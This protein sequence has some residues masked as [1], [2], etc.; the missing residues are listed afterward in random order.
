M[1]IYVIR[2]GRTNNNDLGLFNG[3]TDED[4]ND[5]GIEQAKKVRDT[6]RKI[7]I[8]LIICSPMKRT[9]HTADII[10]INNIPII[11]DDRLIE[12]D[13]GDI[14]LMPYEIIDR[15]E[16]WNR[17]STKYKNVE[18]VNNLLRRVYSCINDI[19]KNYNNKNILIVTHNG[20]ARAIYAYFN[21]MPKDG[22]IWKIGTQK[23]CEIR[24]Y[25][26]EYDI[27]KD[28]VKNVKER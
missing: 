26:I 12:R 10:N 15:E 18:T 3:R 22:K 24:K 11:Y 25:N 21:G 19:I 6:L 16:Y 27:S 9:K 2:H 1:N 5:I 8:D 20:V 23:N 28:N 13:T 4:I 7:N 17:Y 14:T